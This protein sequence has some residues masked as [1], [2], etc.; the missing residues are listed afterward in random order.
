MENITILLEYDHIYSNSYH[1]QTNGMIGRFNA[2]F[3]P[4]I[5][6]LQDTQHSNWDEYLQAVVFVYNTG[7]HKSTKY[8]PFE[9]L[10]GRPSQLPI[11][12]RPRHLSFSKPNDYFQQLQKTLRLYHQAARVHTTLQ[13]EQRKKTYD[14]NRRDLKDSIGDAV[15]TRVHRNRGKLDPRFSPIPK[16]II[17]E[18]HPTY[19]VFDEESQVSSQVHVADLPPLRIEEPTA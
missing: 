18:T 17:Q 6:K 14:V 1:P 4:Q 12:P 19:E 16:L 8:C 2:K 5:A 7:L 13:Q 3:V 11:H 9:L 10:Y 15:L